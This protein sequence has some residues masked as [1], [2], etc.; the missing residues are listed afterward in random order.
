MAAIRDTLAKADILACREWRA[1]LHP[2]HDTHATAR[3]LPLFRIASPNRGNVFELSCA[4]QQI[5]RTHAPSRYAWPR[6]WGSGR[7]NRRW[8]AHDIDHM[9]HE[10]REKAFH[11]R[12]QPRHNPCLIFGVTL[13]IRDFRIVAVG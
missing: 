10:R 5:G 11:M 8:L 3:T 7:L 12:P 1:R 4:H 9:F 13:L 2:R 6:L